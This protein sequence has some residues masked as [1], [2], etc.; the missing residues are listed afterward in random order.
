[1]GIFSKI[2]DVFKKVVRK[3]GGVIKKVTSP[4]RKVLRKVMKPFG[5]LFGKLGWVGTLALGIIFPGF[6]SLLGGWM[7][8][9]TKI[10]M[11]P[12]QWL[13]Q[14]IAPNM[15]KFLGKVV[16]GIKTAGKTVFSSVTETF[17]HGLNKIG[18]AFGYGDPGKLIWDPKTKSLIS[19][20]VE[21]GAATLTEA[22]GNFVSNT[23]DKFLGKPP[24]VEE[25][26]GPPLPDIAPVDDLGAFGPDYNV[27]EGGIT[28][29]TGAGTIPSP[30]SS[31]Y[32]PDTQY[33]TG[34]S[35]LPS[36][37]GGTSPYVDALNAIGQPLVNPSVKGS[38][39]GGSLLGN[40]MDRVS[41]KLG[42][43]QE[44]ASNRAIFGLEKPVEDQWG[45]PTGETEA[46]IGTWGDAG[47][48][49]GTVM[50]GMDT[51]NQYFRDDPVLDF[52][53]STSTVAYAN[54]MLDQTNTTNAS[55]IGDL[56]FTDLSGRSSSTFTQAA[57]DYISGFGLVM[58]PAGQEIA[59]AN[60]L[61]GYNY[62][63]VDSIQQQMGQF[64]PDES[65]TEFYGG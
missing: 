8:G 13:G 4:I 24:G 37:I 52:P 43:W 3:V 58:P 33:F 7:Q 32:G 45:Y 36:G 12:F 48:A 25:V 65:T 57:Q 15:T 62:T 23:R 18:K 41:G 51:Y 6:G 28:S 19:S 5:K 64:M 14:T 20:G 29:R 60:N 42:E 47:S 40:V 26:A 39:S 21:K 10:V 11:A 61:P 38:A 30:F 56:A 9:L 1:M 59:F 34:Q 44:A 2:K 49:G 31:Q 63:F 27:M 17:K 35:N 54:A 16:S 22:F 46:V 53:D 50:K 55:A